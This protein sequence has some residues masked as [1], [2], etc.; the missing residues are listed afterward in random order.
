L[1]PVEYWIKLDE[2][3]NPWCVASGSWIL[4]ELSPTLSIDDGTPVFEGEPIAVLKDPK[5]EAVYGMLL[6]LNVAIS[7]ASIILYAKMMSGLPI[8]VYLSQL[9]W[10]WSDSVRAGVSGGLDGVLSDVPSGIEP[11][12]GLPLMRMGDFKHIRGFDSSSK[13]VIIRMRTAISLKELRSALMDVIYPIN[14]NAIVLV[15]TTLDALRR[16]KKEAEAIRDSVDGLLIN[17][18]GLVSSLSISPARPINLYRCRSCYIDYESESIMKKCPKCQGRLVPL[19]HGR[20][21]EVSDVNKLRARA[22]T[23]LKYLRNAAAQVV[24]SRWFTFKDA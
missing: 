16:N 11:N 19:L 8:Y 12:V 4:R 22:L 5:W 17:P 7:T 6:K 23:N 3:I 9:A 15:E 13:G 18:L 10:P 14:P 21:T 2:C 1:F 24:P 20:V